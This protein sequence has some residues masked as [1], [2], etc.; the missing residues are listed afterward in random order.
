MSQ[1]PE[2]PYPN[3]SALHAAW[4]RGFSDG[5]YEAGGLASNARRKGI[6]QGR[7][8]GAYFGLGV[9]T[10]S[11]DFASIYREAEKINDPDTGWNHFIRDTE[12]GR[13]F[14]WDGQA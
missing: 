5:Q 7:V 1:T 11:R 3:G 4:D 9:A 14:P 6:E 10:Q 12:A 2:N 13:F 8:Q